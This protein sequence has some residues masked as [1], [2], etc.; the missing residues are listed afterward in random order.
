MDAPNKLVRKPSASAP[1]PRPDMLTA[2]PMERAA[3]AFELGRLGRY[4]KELA[5]NGRNATS[6][7]SR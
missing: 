7:R 2:T 3:R 4:V 1:A 6:D 5:R